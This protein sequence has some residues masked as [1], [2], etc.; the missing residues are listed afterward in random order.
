MGWTWEVGA[1]L[2]N[3]TKPYLKKKKKIGLGGARD[4]AQWK[5]ICLACKGSISRKVKKIKRPLLPAF[6]TFNFASQKQLLSCSQHFIA[7]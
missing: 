1:S 5:S 7:L 6:Y 4:V 2:G 3:I